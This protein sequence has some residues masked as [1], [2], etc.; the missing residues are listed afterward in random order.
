[1]LC[2]ACVYA[3]T[4]LPA[5][6]FFNVYAF[7]YSY[8]ADHFQYLASIGPLTVLALAGRTLFRAVTANATAF[9]VAA[10]AIVLALAAMTWN[11][12]ATY[13]DERTLWNATMAKNND[14]WI[15]HHNLA[16]LDS[17]AGNFDAAVKQFDEAIRCKP[18][19]AESYTGRGHASGKLGHLEPAL[20]DLDR[21]IELDPTYPQAYLD[22]GEIRVAARRFDGAIE[23]IDRFLSSNRRHAPAYQV[24]AAAFIELGQLERAIADLDEAVRLGGGASAYHDRAIV[25]LQLGQDATALDDFTRAIELEP[26][27]A[28]LYDGRGFVLVRMGRY[29]NARVD[30]DRAI[31]IDP[32]LALSFVL[33]GGLFQRS[34]GNARRACEDWREACRLGDCKLFNAGCK[35]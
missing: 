34:D 12:A 22:R 31:R 8:V 14:S 5:L 4:I 29:D 33:R 3:I 20:A 21:A 15:A 2:A 18:A 9:R 27:A 1:V 25:R 7:R 30:F 19:A 35:P 11:Q 26:G 10:G 17:K 13:H 23:D 6:G 28:D 24:R 32:S 16:T